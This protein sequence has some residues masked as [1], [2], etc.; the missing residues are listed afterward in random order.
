[1]IWVHPLE[2]GGISLA[3]VST[4]LGMIDRSQ[5]RAT[6][7]YDKRS[8]QRRVRHWIVLRAA[9]HDALL[10]NM[11]IDGSDED[12]DLIMRPKHAGWLLMDSCV[13]IS[14]HR[15]AAGDGTWIMIENPTLQPKDYL[16]AEGF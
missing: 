2:V 14:G 4:I 3:I 6:A 11:T 10:I 8:I 1:M 9:G 13:V 7:R 15:A 12:Y 5:R 16:E